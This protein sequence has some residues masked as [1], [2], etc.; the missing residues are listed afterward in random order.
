MISFI[1]VWVFLPDEM[2]HNLRRVFIIYW[3]DFAPLPCK[4][5][6]NFFSV[7]MAWAFFFAYLSYH[8]LN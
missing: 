4:F 2:E 3:M 1:P 6:Q 5:F 7:F 8:F